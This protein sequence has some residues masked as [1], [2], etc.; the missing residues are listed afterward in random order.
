MG[1]QNVTG[2]LQRSRQADNPKRAYEDRHATVMK[3]V[4]TKGSNL[5]VYKIPDHANI[6]QKNTADEPPPRQAEVGIAEQ[7]RGE[8]E[9][10][11]RYTHLGE[12]G[13][14]MA[15]D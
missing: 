1:K 6:G 7:A 14:R 5:V 12:V 2:E 10:G 3:K 4:I 9:R 8:H 15:N 11:F 13:R